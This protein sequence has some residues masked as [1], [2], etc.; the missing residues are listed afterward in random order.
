MK[1][2]KSQQ[3]YIDLAIKE[4]KKSTMNHKH[5]AVIVKGGVV[6]ASAYN[7]NFSHTQKHDH[8]M[9]SRHAEAEAIIQCKLRNI[10][11]KGADIF[12]VRLTR[13]ERNLA[14]SNPC[15][16]CADFIEE[17]QFAHVYHS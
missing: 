10:S 13:S 14:R 11:L 6:L 4:A 12:V 15:K 3:Q 7:Y 1:L 5:G 16:D 8:S 9:L 2:H 17:N